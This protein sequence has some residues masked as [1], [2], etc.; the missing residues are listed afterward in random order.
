MFQ[1][2]TGDVKKL[3]HTDLDTSVALQK[4]YELLSSVL[5]LLVSV[6]LSR[7]QQNQQSQHQIRQFLDEN[8]SNMV[9]AFKGNRGLGRGLPSQSHAVLEDVIRSYTVLMFMVDY[10]QVR[11]PLKLLQNAFLIGSSWRNR[12]ITKAHYAMGSRDLG[13][14]WEECLGVGLAQPRHTL[15]LSGSND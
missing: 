15:A 4:Y 6:F 10:V 2:K 5:R 14:L 8:R 3:T 11:S 12:G 13:G 9:G 1:D 7:G